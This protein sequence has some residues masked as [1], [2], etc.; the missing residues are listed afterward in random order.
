[1]HSSQRAARRPLVWALSSLI[2]LA[3][4]DAFAASTI[5]VNDTTQGATANELP[6]NTPHYP[7][8]SVVLTM[9]YKI[10]AAGKLQEET[11]QLYGYSFALDPTKTVENIELPANRNIVV[12]S[13]DL[14][15]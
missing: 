8:E 4:C 10:N 1:M 9:P 15:P 2:T 6:P 11:Y 3:A 7:G 12:L 14:M 13:M 5:T